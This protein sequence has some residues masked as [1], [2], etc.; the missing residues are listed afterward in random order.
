MLPGGVNP[1][2]M[3][4]M[5]KKM[6]IKTEEVP[7]EQVII[8]C[9]DKQIIIDEPS[10]ILTVMQGQQMFQIQGS[11]REESAEESVDISQEDVDMVM[12]QTGAK[13]DAVIAALEKSKGDI[14]EA[15]MGLKK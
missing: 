4:K 6:G 5:M 3:K 1:K 8:N 10:V 9:V 11:V 2:Q 7:A 12:A 15:I 14:A 13:E